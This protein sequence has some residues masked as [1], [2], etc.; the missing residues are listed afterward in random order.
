MHGLPHYLNRLN[1]TQG[2]GQMERSFRTDEDKPY[3][4]EELPADLGGQE[5]VLLAWNRVYEQV[6]PHQVPGYK[7][8]EQFYREWLTIH[9]AAKEMLSGMCG[10]VHTLDIFTPST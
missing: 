5:T 8:P 7:T 2:N 3:Q 9:H 1:Y 10:R 4:I 6:R